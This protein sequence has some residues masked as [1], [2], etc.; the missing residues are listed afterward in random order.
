MNHT[1]A[2]ADGHID[3]PRRRA[4]QCILLIG[5]VSLFADMTYEGARN[6]TGPFLAVLGASASVVGIVAGPGELLGYGL[7]LVSGYLSDRTGRYWAIT[8]AHA[9]LFPVHGTRM[10]QWRPLCRP[11]DMYFHEYEGYISSHEYRRADDVQLAELV[12]RIRN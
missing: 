10:P 1:K 6:I 2:L 9:K 11:V 4:L 12:E 3:L 7:R 5:T 8:I